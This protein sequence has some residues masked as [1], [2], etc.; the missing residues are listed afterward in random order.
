L[1][2]SDGMAGSAGAS[3]P[4]GMAGNASNPDLYVGGS[5]NPNTR[6]TAASSAGLTSSTSAPGLVVSGNR[7]LGEDAAS[8]FR[9]SEPS[10]GA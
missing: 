2:G 8:V 10:P 3:G 7:P 4:S 1:T 9:T 6:G 5:V